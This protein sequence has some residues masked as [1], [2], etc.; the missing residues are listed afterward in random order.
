[1]PKK[2]KELTNK[3]INE[4][5]NLLVEG[6]SIGVALTKVTGKQSAGYQAHIL[7]FYPKI[8][9]AYMEIY[10]IKMKIRKMGMTHSFLNKIITIEN[11]EREI[12]GLA[13]KPML[14]PYKTKANRA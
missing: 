5:I 3:E 12:R 11:K 6:W 13:P 14:T 9:R 4:V 10:K 8:K 2:R 7:N 1:M